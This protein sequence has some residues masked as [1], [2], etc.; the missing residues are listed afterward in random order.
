MPK[1]RKLFK[2]LEMKSTTLIFFSALIFSLFYNWPFYQKILEVY[3]LSWNYFLFLSSLF[4]SFT[5]LLNIALNLLC[6]RQS[7]KFVLIANFLLAAA[8][9]YILKTFGTIIDDIMIL[10]ILQTET[11]EALDIITVKSI[12][13]FFFWGVL[14]AV[15]VYKIK[16]TKINFSYELLSKLRSISLSLGV[17]LICFLLNMKGFA[18]F[19]REHKDLR[20]YSNPSYFYYSSYKFAKN[21]FFHTDNKFIQIGKDAKISE[22]DTERELVIFVVGET[23]R[24]D[25]FS[26]NGY[27][28]ETNPLLKKENIINFSNVSSCGTSTAISVPCMFSQMNRDQF[29]ERKAQN[30]ENLLDVLN[31]TKK[32]NILWRD[33]NSNSKKVADRIQ[34][35]DYKSSSRN[36]ICA[37]KECRDEGMLVGLQEYINQKKDGDIFIVLH[38]LGSHGPT[39]YKRYPSTFE[40]FKPT[41]KSGQLETCTTEEINNS[42]DNTILYTDYFLSKVIQLLK[43]N[44][45]QFE[46]AMFYVSDH[47]ESL[48]ENNIY[49][50]GLPYFIAPSA[51]KH[52]PMVLWFGEKLN[53]RLNSNLLRAKAE[54][55]F[56]HDNIFHSILGLLE[57][58]TQLYQPKLD[59]FFNDY[60]SSL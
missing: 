9:G 38:Q 25:H 32:A 20:S 22:K 28:K 33:N 3:P 24:A 14:P 1:F 23:A 43:K 6:I 7:V 54:N 58:K 56:S 11:R 35:E 19:L 12:L 15:L 37:P 60:T 46:T 2:E 53:G 55:E 34:Y 42:Y 40:K 13:S 5:A 31:H 29:S 57:V 45:N 4:I 52:V 17:I 51:Q 48:G 10:N 16:L 27:S 26:L 8:I 50:H 18:S 41:C 44:S 39:Y 30:T 21:H 36:T 49:L 47:G 59:I